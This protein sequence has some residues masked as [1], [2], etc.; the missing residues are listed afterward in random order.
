MTSRPP[1]RYTPCP[2]ECVALP[3]QDKTTRHLLTAP[4]VH[5]LAVVP[6]RLAD[7]S[8]ERCYFST[9]KSSAL[10]APETGIG[11]KSYCRAVI[12]GDHANKKQCS[13]STRDYHRRGEL[14][15]GCYHQRPRRLAA[16]SWLL[17]PAP[18][19]SCLR[20]RLRFSLLCAFVGQ[21]NA[22]ARVVTGTSLV[23]TADHVIAPLP[24]R[25]SDATQQFFL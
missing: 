21:R 16:A 12:T 22:L 3:H 11:E 17:R 6:H 14:V 20:S 24:R 2:S 10:S 19:R 4:S 5:R 8:L 15:Q 25:R 18:T 13:I 1:P 9:P 23:V 7:Y